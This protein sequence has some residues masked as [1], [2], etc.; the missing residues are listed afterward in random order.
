MS[1][2]KVCEDLT[3]PGHFVVTPHHRGVQALN[4]PRPDWDGFVGDHSVRGHRLALTLDFHSSQCLHVE[5]RSYQAE[6]IARYLDGAGGGCLLHAGG[7]VHGVAHRR[8]F[9]CLIGPDFA[10]HHGTRVDAN[11]D[12]EI[13]PIVALKL[14]LELLDPLKD[15]QSGQYGTLWIV[16]M[17]VWSAKER[18]NAVAHQ[19]SDRASVPVDRLVQIPEDLVHDLRPFFGIEALGQGSG[20][21]YVAEQYGDDA[22][23]S[24][25]LMAGALRTGSGVG[26]L[27]DILHLRLLAP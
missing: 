6:G 20:A 27:T 19:P 3:Q 5:E 9:V 7:Q 22:T 8:V 2:A 11:P 26:P 15:A 17:G 21:G 1:L 13:L 25:P 12:V 23:L 18:E 24:G 10:H 4:T 14:L 16:L